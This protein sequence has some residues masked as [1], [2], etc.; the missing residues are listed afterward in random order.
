MQQKCMCEM[1]REMEERYSGG[2]RE[3]QR[4]RG[5][6]KEVKEERAAWRWREAGRSFP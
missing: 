5:G 6:A 2:G 4:Q 1:Q 3:T